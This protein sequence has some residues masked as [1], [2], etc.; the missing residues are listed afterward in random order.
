VLGRVDV[1]MTCV[2]LKE[3]RNDDIEDIVEIDDQALWIDVLTEENCYGIDGPVGLDLCF[4]RDGLWA[5]RW[6]TPDR[7]RAPR[8]TVSGNG[9]Q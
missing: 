6:W 1:M 3:G 9:G 7:H 5:A 4:G 8:A 2:V